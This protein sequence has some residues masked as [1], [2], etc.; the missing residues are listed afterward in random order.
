M[1]PD[2]A[3]AGADRRAARSGPRRRHHHPHARTAADLAL[4]RAGRYPLGCSPRSRRASLRSR[5]YHR[6]HEIDAALMKRVVRI[7]RRRW[8]AG[9]SRRAPRSAGARG[10]GHR[11]LRRPARP[12]HDL[13]RARAGDLQRAAPGQAVHLRAVRRAR[14]AAP[15]SPPRTRARARGALRA[16]HGPVTV[17]DFVWWSGLT[18]GEAR[19]AFRRCRRRC[20]PRQIGE[21]TY[22]SSATGPKA[23]RVTCRR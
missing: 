14:A 8:A 6:A 4:H 22:W 19:R 10:Q 16:S 18:V 23:T 12:D 17:N 7:S 9:R 20:A 5:R 3:R 15:R 2:A 11:G 21:D 13:G 1:G